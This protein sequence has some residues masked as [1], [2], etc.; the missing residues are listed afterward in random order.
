MPSCNKSRF[1]VFL[2]LGLAAFLNPA[3]PALAQTTTIVDASNSPYTVP[4]TTIAA[5]DTVRVVSGGSLDPNQ[6]SITTAGTLQFAPTAAGGAVSLG[7]FLSGTG[8]V[9]KTGDGTLNVNSGNQTFAGNWRFEEGVTVTTDVGSSITNNSSNYYGPNATWTFAGGFFQVANN[10][11]DFG[12]GQRETIITPDGGGIDVSL[13]TTGVQSIEGADGATRLGIT[14]S[15]SFTVKGVGTP[16]AGFLLQ[17]FVAFTNQNTYSGSTILDGGA[18]VLNPNSFDSG[19]SCFGTSV[20]TLT[21]GATLSSTFNSTTIGNPQNILQ[22]S[23]DIVLGTGGGQLHSNF[24][25]PSQYNQIELTGTVSGTGSL[26]LFAGY[27]ILSGS[28]TFSGNTRLGGN[29]NNVLFLD[30]VNALAGSTLDMN[31]ADQGFLQLTNSNTFYKLGGLTGS[32]TLVQQSGTSNVALEIGSNDQDTTFTGNFGF[33]GFR[34]Y[35]GIIKSGTGTLTLTGTYFTNTSPVVSTPGIQITGGTLAVNSDLALGA[36]LSYGQANTVATTLDGGTLKQSSTLSLPRPLVLGSNGGGLDTTTSTAADTPAFTGVISGSGPLELIAN[37]DLTGTATGGVSLGGVNTFTG[38]TTITAG[39]VQAQSSFGSAAN[40]V[41]L[42]GGGLLAAGG[43]RGN[44]YATEIGQ[45]TG[46]LRAAGASDVFSQ[47]GVVS[48]SGGLRVSGSGTVNLQ[49][50]N[51]F[52]GDTRVLT[53]TLNL[54]DADALAA[55]LLDMDGTD[56]G[57]VGFTAGTTTYNVGGL[58]GSRN[59]AFSAGTLSV[60]GG[61]LSTTYSGVLSGNGVFDKAGTGTLTLSGANTY[62]GGTTVSAGTLAGDVTSLQG[63]I[64]NDAAVVFNQGTDGSYAGIMSGTGTLTKTGAGTL[65]LS[66][67]NTYSGGTT[68]SAGTL[69][70]SASHLQGAITNNATVEFDQAAAGTYSGAMSGTGNLVKNGAGALTL[71]G[72][73]SYAGTTTVSNGTL[74]INGDN[75]AVTTPISLVAG[76]TIG[77]SGTHGG[78]ITIAANTTLSPGTSPGTFTAAAAAWEADGDYNW[79]LVNAAGSAGSDW[80]L[81]NVTGVLDITATSGTPFNV[82]LWTLSSTGPDVDGSATNFSSNSQYSWTLASAAGGVTNFAADKFQVNTASTNGTAGFAN[83]FGSGQFSIANA[84]ND[85]NLD[86]SPAVVFNVGTGTSETQV[87]QGA[88]ANM[89]TAVSVTKT[90]AGTV[91]M[92]GTNSYAAATAVDAGT[93]EVTGSL[94]NSALTVNSGGTLSGTGTVAQLATVLGGGTLAPGAA[95]PAGT[96][97]LSLGGLSLASTA[98]TVI[99]ITGPTPGTDFDQVSI[100]GSGSLGFGGTLDLSTSNIDSAVAGTSYRLFDFS[101]TPTGDFASLTSLGGIYA[102]ITWSGP[103]GGVWTSTAGTGGDFL[104]FN[105]GTGTLAVV[106]EPSTFALAAI[107][108]LGGLAMLRRR[109]RSTSAA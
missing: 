98:T 61:N 53:G 82:N 87:Q 88:V 50:A 20:V 9:L 107:A 24:N 75:S 81:L 34:G 6:G 26:T 40:Q 97:I 72:N 93:L 59:I 31:A 60:G 105:Q 46:T 25:N 35:D 43:T 30:N 48:G 14:G 90:G 104:T 79:Q 102:G 52:T 68:V 106:P 49:A 76:T 28:N 108:G 47:S 89:T 15:G 11:R 62:S 10:G 12:I 109:T 32:R 71:S 77:G 66:G 2:T 57:T 85:L 19:G 1:I 45:A 8:T 36:N 44:A 54:A 38:T 99:A 74:L 83:S 5:G 94:T 103:A 84:G 51:T 73:S 91:V 18:F 86:F 56:T 33:Q 65:T 92:N 80:D 96:G 69:K 42:D 101:S 13:Q 67:T 21:Q 70:G 22:V 7:N 63:A 58:Q 41:V 37:G 16:N 95:S 78:L 64:A 100:L 4:G 29:A 27:G 23:N 17:P 55:S 3:R 39:M